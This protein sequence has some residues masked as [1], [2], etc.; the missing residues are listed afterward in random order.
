MRAQLC[1]QHG[2]AK[3]EK[4]RKNAQTQRPHWEA[5]WENPLWIHGAGAAVPVRGIAMLQ[6]TGA[7]RPRSAN[8]AV[9]SATRILPFSFANQGIADI[10]MAWS[11]ASSLSVYSKALR[12]TLLIHFLKT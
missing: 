5:R 11:V 10:A 3:M 2:A 8:K 12:R 4:R 9:R 1:V 7:V 6:P